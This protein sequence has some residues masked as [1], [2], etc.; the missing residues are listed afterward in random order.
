MTVIHDSHMVFSGNPYCVFCKHETMSWAPLIKEDTVR[1]RALTP[2]IPVSG[3]HLGSIVGLWTDLTL[4]VVILSSVKWRGCSKWPLPF[5]CIWSFTFS[6]M[7]S[8][9]NSTCDCRH[10]P[11]HRLPSEK[12]CMCLLSIWCFDLKFEVLLKGC[13]SL[14]CICW[15]NSQL[16]L[17]CFLT[18]LGDKYR[19]LP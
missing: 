2:V 5:L 9:S 8:L 15:I 13:C 10:C 16:Q 6:I 18:D 3:S 4:E 11:Y 1:G 17:Q 14:I 7:L 19:C 12:L